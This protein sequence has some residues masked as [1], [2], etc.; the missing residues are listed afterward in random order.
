MFWIYGGAFMVGDSYEFGWYDAKNFV[1]KNDV[2][3][4]AANYRVNAFGFFAHEAL[5]D[6]DGKT[7]D[8]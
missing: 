5:K 7:R 2:I 4:V 6:E 8:G 3:V 1:Q